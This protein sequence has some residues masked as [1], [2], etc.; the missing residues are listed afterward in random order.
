M[1]RPFRLVCERG[2]TYP[3]KGSGIYCVPRSHSNLD[4]PPM[5]VFK[6]RGLASLVTVAGH[7]TLPSWLSAAPAAAA[8]AAV[9]YI[10]SIQFSTLASRKLPDVLQSCSR[11]T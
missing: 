5:A 8:T 7:A 11:Y 3:I 6:A 4:R 2:Y 9:S 1:Y 10:G